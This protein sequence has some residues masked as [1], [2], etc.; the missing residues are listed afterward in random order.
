MLLFLNNNKDHMEI[1]ISHS[2]KT[3]DNTKEIKC[4]KINHNNKDVIKW[5]RMLV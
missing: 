1:K 5:L 4:F 3:V 2:I